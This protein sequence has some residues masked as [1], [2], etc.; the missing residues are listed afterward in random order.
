MLLLIW[1]RMRPSFK[2]ILIGPPFVPS[3]FLSAI[4]LQS[5]LHA[6]ARLRIKGSLQKKKKNLKKRKNLWIPTT[7]NGQWV[8][9]FFFF[10]AIFTLQTRLYLSPAC[11]REGFSLH[12]SRRRLCSG[13]F[14]HFA[15]F[16]PLEGGGDTRMRWYLGYRRLRGRAPA[17][18]RVPGV[19]A[20]RGGDIMTCQAASHHTGLPA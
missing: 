12:E 19:S 2:R 9:F 11:N 7:V 14:S 6:V 4:C 1:T 16:F 10:F 18:T 5:Y 20:G 13:V 17:S 3:H 8:F 15:L